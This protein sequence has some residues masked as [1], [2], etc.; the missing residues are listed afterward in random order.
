[1]TMRTAIGIVL[2]GAKKEYPD[3]ARSSKE[4][5]D[6]SAAE[7]PICAPALPVLLTARKIAVVGCKYWITKLPVLLCIMSFTCWNFGHQK[8][9]HT[10]TKQVYHPG[11][12]V[13][14]PHA[15]QGMHL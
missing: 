8:R 9:Q 13:R 14:Q 7:R 12:Q 2:I 6:P 15:P 4:M 1:M 3:K 5:M 11:C 10:V